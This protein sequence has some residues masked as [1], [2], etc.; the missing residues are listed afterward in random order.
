LSLVL[1]S[2]GVTF[3]CEAFF[4]K[5]G[6]LLGYFAGAIFFGMLPFTELGPF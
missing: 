2:P 1:F 5:A 4:A 6:S 3:F